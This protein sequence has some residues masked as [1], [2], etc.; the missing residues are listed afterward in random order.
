MSSMECP[1]CHIEMEFN[2]KI[3]WSGYKGDAWIC[4]KCGLR[5]FVR[6]RLNKP[7]H[8]NEPEQVELDVDKLKKQMEDYINSI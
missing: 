8:L 1:S 4:K 7:E 5:Y 2:E 3:Q 6:I